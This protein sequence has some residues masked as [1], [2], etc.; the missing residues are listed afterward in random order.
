M[1][2]ENS[3]DILIGA[4]K[5]GKLPHAILF[6]GDNVDTLEEDAMRLAGEILGCAPVKVV[7]H[8]DFHSVKPIGKA[9]EIR[10]ASIRESIRDI[11]LSPTVGLKKVAFIYDAD[12]FNEESANAFLKTLEEPPADTTI[13][14]LT[15]RF[16][17]VLATI[18]SRTLN[19][20]MTSSLAGIDD[21]EWIS[22]RRNYAQWIGHI[23]TLGRDA[24]SVAKLVSQAFGLSIAFDAVVEKTTETAL[25]SELDA[26]KKASMNAEEKDAFEV[27]L[28]KRLR[29]RL[30]KEFEEETAKVARELMKENEAIVLSYDLVINDLEHM[31]GLMEL[32]MK[33]ST[34][35]EWFLLRSLRYWS[36]AKSN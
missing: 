22:W 10:V 25:G 11:Q 14:L 36:T 34:A 13:V 29:Q 9:R 21:P 2:R 15:S 27:S 28:S 32:N 1:G 24:I 7:S 26:E 5:T 3:I 12:R 8:A 6:Y 20:R 23:I 18:R 31:K 16:Y 17:D 33:S 35:I 30:M 19:F 4:A